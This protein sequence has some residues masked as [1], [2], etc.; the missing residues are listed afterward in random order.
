[1]LTGK[2]KKLF[3]HGRMKSVDLTRARWVGVA[4]MRGGGSK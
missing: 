4:K 1:M 2:K 3:V